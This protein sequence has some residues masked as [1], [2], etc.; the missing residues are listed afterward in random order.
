MTAAHCVPLHSHCI[1]WRPLHCVHAIPQA[2]VLSA[3]VTATYFDGWRND[4]FLVIGGDDADRKAQRTGDT[5]FA[6]T[7][8][9]LRAAGADAS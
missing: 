4:A 6:R 3:K 9:M 1:L 8:G 5:I 7:R 2:V